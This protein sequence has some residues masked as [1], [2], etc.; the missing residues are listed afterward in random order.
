MGAFRPGTGATSLWYPKGA[1][2]GR[3]DF[4][5]LAAVVIQIAMLAWR[6]IAPR[7]VH[8][9]PLAFAA[10]W[11]LSEYARGHLFT[12]FPWNLA[13][14]GW[15]FSDSMSQSAA[16]IGICGPSVVRQDPPHYRRCNQ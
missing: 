4:L 5:F 13:G 7:A 12:G 9:Q 15:A 10:L 16:F 1:A 14:Y 11:S 3:Y 8:W 2:L 6:T